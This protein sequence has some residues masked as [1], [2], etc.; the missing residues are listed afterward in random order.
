MK[1][2]SSFGV[3]GS[4]IFFVVGCTL[5]GVGYLKI[6][7][8]EMEV[9]RTFVEGRCTIL[10]KSL[11]TT[12][13]RVRRKHGGSR[14]RTHYRPEFHIRH[15]VEGQS[16]EARTFRI[17][18]SSSSS[19]SAEEAVLARY[20]VGKS[21]PCWYDPGDPGRVVLEK[22]LSS[23]GIAITSLGALFALIGAWL[24]LRGGTRRSDA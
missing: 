23:A 5:T 1:K 2:G 21:Y 22:G 13:R 14:R 18:N 19:Q 15:E 17:V 16:Y 11:E 7:R 8:P 10:G 9:D 12:E 20:E 4:L 6:L 24:G 3:I